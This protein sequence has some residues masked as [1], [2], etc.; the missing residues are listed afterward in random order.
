MAE[1]SISMNVNEIVE[2]DYLVKEIS[3]SVVTFDKKPGNVSESYISKN[4][5]VFDPKD[6][7]TYKLDINGQKIEI[8]VTDIP[9]SATY[10]WRP[11][12]YTT[13]DA[14]WDDENVSEA[15]SLSGDPQSGTLSNG[16]TAVVGDGN[17]TGVVNVQD[18]AGYITSSSWEW[19][20]Q[21][22]LSSG[23]QNIYGGNFSNHVFNVE[24]NADGDFNNQLGNIQFFL[25][26]T[27]GNTFSFAPS[28]NP[29]LD[30]GNEHKVTLT[31]NGSTSSDVNLII[32]GSSVS[33]SFPRSTS[34]S[35]P[36]SWEEN[37]GV[38]GAY[39][40]S[41]ITS[42]NAAKFGVLAIHDSVLSNHSF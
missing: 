25:R 16:D 10:Y 32:D 19:Q 39:D 28:T 18:T 22:T 4:K 9:N 20:I 6:T 17:D 5:Y 15:I 14:S 24:L 26:G 23:R 30:D 8:E 27:A 40:G 29:N 12:S 36:S 3:D 11:R 2:L 7:G 34:W 13:G 38:W 42:S 1:K 33:L 41:S 21:H 35:P 31:I 37:F